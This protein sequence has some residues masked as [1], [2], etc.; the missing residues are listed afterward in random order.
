MSIRACFSLTPSTHNQYGETMRAINI[1]I[2]IMLVSI[3]ISAVNEAYTG[4]AG[5]I[6]YNINITQVNQSI[7]DLVT[8]NGTL[9]QLTD[10]LGTVRTSVVMLF[11]ILKGSLFLGSTMQELIQF[12]MPNSLVIGLNVMSLV[13]ISLALIQFI[14]GLATRYSD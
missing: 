11:E 10:M 3:S 8:T 5:D 12:P 9:D 2:F 13:S 14:R 1:A 6:Q 7:Q 4:Q